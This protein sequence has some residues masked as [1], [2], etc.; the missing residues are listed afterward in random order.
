[1]KSTAPVVTKITGKRTA[2]R[3]LRPPNGRRDHI[4]SRGRMKL[5]TTGDVSVDLEKAD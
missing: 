4:H 3:N 2:P 5:S 1:M